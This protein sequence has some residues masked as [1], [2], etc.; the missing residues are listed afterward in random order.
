MWLQVLVTIAINILSQ[1]LM[2]ASAPKAQ[3]QQRDPGKLDIPTPEEGTTVS[4]IFGTVLKKDMTVAWYGDAAT[5]EIRSSGQ[6]K[7]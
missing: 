3:D 2:A 6:G 1:V 5:T 4:V 7:K